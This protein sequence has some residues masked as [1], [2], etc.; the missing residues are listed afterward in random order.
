MRRAHLITAMLAGRRASFSPDAGVRSP[1]PPKTA[2]T[3][4]MTGLPVSGDETAEQSY[5]VLVTKLD[6]TSSSRPR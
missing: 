4:P 3:W 5:P 2:S 1:P 6:N